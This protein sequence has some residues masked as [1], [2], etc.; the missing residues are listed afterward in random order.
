MNGRK[1]E[2]LEMAYRGL[3]ALKTNG[4]TELDITEDMH[5]SSV[6]H[7]IAYDRLTKIKE[8]L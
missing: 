2:L 3:L 5:P 1:M 4:K 7:S 6:T 8:R